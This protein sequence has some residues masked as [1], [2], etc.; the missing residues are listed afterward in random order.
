M[1]QLFGCVGANEPAT[2]KLWTRRPRHALTICRL[3]DV[4]KSTFWDSV[5]LIKQVEGAVIK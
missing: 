4:N 3:I 1:M 2:S 5:K